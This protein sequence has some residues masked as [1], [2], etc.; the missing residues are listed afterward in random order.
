MEIERTSK[1]ILLKISPNIDKFGMEKVLEYIEYLEITS[2]YD[3]VDQKDADQLAEELNQD[4]WER[5][6]DRFIK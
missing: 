1:E 2:G 5:N 6:K 4:W 3:K